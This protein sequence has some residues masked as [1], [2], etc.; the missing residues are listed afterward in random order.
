LRGCYGGWI[1]PPE[2]PDALAD[3][4]KELGASR[5]LR[6]KIGREAREKISRE[7]RIEREVEQYVSL[8]DSIIDGRRSV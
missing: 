8:Y 1:V 4:L 6:E 3:A 2:N 7:Y 5:E